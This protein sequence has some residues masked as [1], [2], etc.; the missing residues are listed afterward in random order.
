MINRKEYMKAYMKTY[1]KGYWEKNSARLL[2]KYRFGG[3]R[4]FILE[5]DNW[6]CVQCGMKQEQHI[7]L[8]GHSL[9]IDHIDGKGRYSENQN[10]NPD[11]LQ[12]LCLRCHGI[13]DISRRK[14]RP[15]KS[16]NKTKR[17]VN[18]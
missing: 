9:T 1:W 17:G 13:K 8:F 3:L 11:N 18:K 10:N 2:S 14:W 6:Q 15:I 12:T 4:D 16:H 5:R 7:I